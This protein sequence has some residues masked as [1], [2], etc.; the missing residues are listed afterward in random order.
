MATDPSFASVVKLGAALLGAVETNLQ[1]PTTTSTVVT[2]G[3]S[4]TKI[5]E[6]VVKATNTTLVA[7]TIAGLVYLFLHDGSTYHL[8][9]DLPVSAVTS[10]ATVASFR[11]SRT[12]SNLWIPSG[13][14]LRASQSANTASILKCEVFGA[15][16]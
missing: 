10:S 3:A 5:E 14:S 11:Y 7:T 1:V 9:D 13:W 15:D 16:Y 4:G 2:A 8:Y 6:V 12:Y